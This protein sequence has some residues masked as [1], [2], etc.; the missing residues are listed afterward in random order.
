M[1]E[2]VAPDTRP[3]VFVEHRLEWRAWLEANHGRADGIWVG[4]WKKHTGRPRPEYEDLV[5]EA[6]CF[7][8]VDSKG[9]RLDD[10]RTL[11]WLAP[12]KAKSAWSRPNK[13][14]VERLTAGGLMAPAGLRAVEQAKANGTWTMLDDVEGLVVPPDLEEA[15]LRYPG[16]RHQWDAFPRSPRR[17]ILE[18]IMQAKRPA[19]RASRVEETAR[20]AAEGIR[21][22][23]WRPKS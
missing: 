19:T 7:G 1:E 8:W 5:E 14:R 6:L 9:N 16:A 12:R 3:A 13:E 4:T 22:N 18:W 20:L 17:A 10:D 15:F 11:L 23:Q 2:F 21:A